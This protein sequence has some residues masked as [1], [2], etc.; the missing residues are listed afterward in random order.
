[1]RVVINLQ[2]NTHDLTFCPHSLTPPWHS[3]RPGGWW[4]PPSLPRWSDCWSSPWPQVRSLAAH[5]SWPRV[6]LTP[7]VNVVTNSKIWPNIFSFENRVKWFTWI[8]NTV[9][10]AQVLT[11]LPSNLLMLFD[12]LIKSELELLVL[13]IQ[14]LKM[15]V[16]KK[17]NTT[18]WSEITFCKVWIF[19]DNTALS[20]VA[21]SAISVTH[22]WA[23]P[24]ITAVDS[25]IHLWPAAP[26]A[27]PTRALRVLSCGQWSIIV[28]LVSIF[29][30]QE[31][32]I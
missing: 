16:Y 29:C 4:R 19:R 28:S 22:S 21:L 30:A 23:S 12:Q 17:M 6:Q 14:F 1:M 9:Q 31:S 20:F 3:S 27:A 2:S 25:A 24:T 11:G 5:L 26:N 13:H 15:T 8:P 7:W 10:S 18:I 32:W